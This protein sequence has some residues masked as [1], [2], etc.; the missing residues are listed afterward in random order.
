MQQMQV[1]GHCVGGGFDRLKALI[2]SRVS[3]TLHVSIGW[4]EKNESC[5]L[6]GEQQAATATG[7]GAGAGAAVKCK[8]DFV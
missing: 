8:R 3:F 5:W 1:H 4:L 7:A 6:S 2:S